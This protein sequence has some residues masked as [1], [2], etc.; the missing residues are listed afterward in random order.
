[1]R[2]P[3]R[4]NVVNQI[5][6]HQ[7]VARLIDGRGGGRAL[8]ADDVD[9]DVVVVVD[10]V[11]RDAEVRDVPVHNERLART[12]L[13][14][15]HLIAVNDQIS[16]R[17]LGVGAVYGNAKSVATASRSIAA[18][19]SLLNVMHVVFQKFDV[20]TRTANVDAQRRKTMFSCVKVANFEALNSHV[21]LVVNGE[22]ALSSS[23][24]EMPSV[25]HRRLAGI[26]SEGNESIVR[27]P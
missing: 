14:V 24:G 6:A 2:I 7:S 18:W 5:A 17:S 10:D 26:A 19:E 4:R 15:M 9:S 16:D 12:C 22:N 13:E 25:Q 23:G 11:V 1:C 27:I 8:K 21:T 20:G 3:S